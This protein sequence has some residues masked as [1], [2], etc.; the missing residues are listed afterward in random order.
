MNAQ[1]GINLITL[2]TLATSLILLFITGRY[3][4][5][6]FRMLEEMRLHSHLLALSIAATVNTGIIQMPAVDELGGMQT[7]AL[8]E[9]NKL[10]KQIEKLLM[11]L[12]ERAHLE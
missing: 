5:S 12:R 1:Q 6:T 8:L 7:N 11:Q 4:H 9:L 3:A 10:Q 2:A